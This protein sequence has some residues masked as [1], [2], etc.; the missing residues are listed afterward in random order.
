MEKV[1]GPILDQ[2]HSHVGNIETFDIRDHTD[3]IARTQVLEDLGDT[4]LGDIVPRLS[5]EP[6]FRFAYCSDIIHQGV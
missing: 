1:H 3:D 4:R 5:I 2:D 6:R